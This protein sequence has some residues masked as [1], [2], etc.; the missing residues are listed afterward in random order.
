MGAAAFASSASLTRCRR[1]LLF[2]LEGRRG[3][4]GLGD[5]FL[6]LLEICDARLDGGVERREERMLR[7]ALAD[8]R[9]QLLRARDV[10]VVD[11]RCTRPRCPCD[12]AS[13]PVST[14]DFGGAA[15]A[16]GAAALPV[17]ARPPT[18]RKYCPLRS[19]P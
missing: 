14:G 15:P 7:I 13:A 3:L 19:P 9:G 8:R 17:L 2:F 16:A 12:P 18:Q 11:A 1:S 6:A 5:R 4:R 10:V